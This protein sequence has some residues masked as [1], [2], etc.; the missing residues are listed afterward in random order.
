MIVLTLQSQ[1][2]GI[3]FCHSTNSAVLH[4]QFSKCNPPLLAFVWNCSKAY[5]N[6]SLLQFFLHA[7][8]ARGFFDDVG[9][10]AKAWRVWL[11]IPF[12]SIMW[13]SCFSL[14]DSSQHDSSETSEKPEVEVTVEGQFLGSLISVGWAFLYPKCVFQSL[15]YLAPNEENW[16]PVLSAVW[17]VHCLVNVPS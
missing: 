17:I 13:Q 3:S 16:V 5:G 9:L 14:S 2:C 8:S 12:L 10:N 7:V 4:T 15:H 11:K 1:H 6:I